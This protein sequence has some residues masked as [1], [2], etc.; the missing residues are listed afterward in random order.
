VTKFRYEAITTAKQKEFSEYKDLTAKHNW[1]PEVKKCCS[2]IFVMENDPLVML[3]HFAV[4][5][6][7]AM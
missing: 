5:V 4:A 3:Y 7:H 6:V 1:T 2:S